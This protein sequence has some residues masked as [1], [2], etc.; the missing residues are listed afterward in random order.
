[1]LWGNNL[2]KINYDNILNPK[3]AFLEYLDNLMPLYVGDYGKE[4]IKLIKDRIKKT[5]YIFDSLPVHEINFLTSCEDFCNVDSKLAVAIEECR[6]FIKKK[7]NI[8][9]KIDKKR[10]SI[11][12]EIF[13]AGNRYIAELFELDIDSYS[14]ENQ[15]ALGDEDVSDKDKAEIRKR[16]EEYHMDCERLNIKCITD[17]MVIEKIFKVSDQLDFDT[18]ILLAQ[19]TKWANRIRN[20]IFEDTGIYLDDMN[21]SE[22]LFSSATASSSI[23][24]IS[25]NKSI[26]ICY[27]P[28]ARNF[29]VG[30]LDGM[31]F[32]EN[33][34]IVEMSEEYAGVQCFNGGRY[35]SINEIRTEKNAIR[36][37]IRLESK[38]L[39][40][41]YAYCENN[42]NVYEMVFPYTGE[43]FDDHLGQLNKLA[44]KN[45]IRN[46]ERLYGRGNLKKFDR[47]LTEIIEAI[48]NDTWG[49]SIF[50]DEKIEKQLIMKLNE[51]FKSR[52]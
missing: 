22:L 48:N 23:I 9:E 19:K 28:L 12:A 26:R 44:L 39:F 50:H 42:L 18:N 8:D 14:L 38:V 15:I 7:K 20:R 32:H 27:F 33:R 29:F 43:F 3:E 30:N 40:S 5:V 13:R 24:N 37:K 31:F 45:D 21:L 10:Y 41:N 17:A 36:D 2:K 1:M 46:F 34:H 16:Q 51:R 52:H 49:F 6:D 11:L 35:C 4:N 25:L 47:Y